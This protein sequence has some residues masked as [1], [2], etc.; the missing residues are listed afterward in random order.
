MPSKIKP[1]KL[2]DDWEN[3]AKLDRNVANRPVVKTPPNRIPFESLSN[4]TSKQSEV[5]EINQTG[6]SKSH[7]FSAT[8][9]GIIW[10]QENIQKSFQIFR[11]IVWSSW[12]ISMSYSYCKTKQHAIRSKQIGYDFLPL[13]IVKTNSNFCMSK[14]DKKRRGEGIEFVRHPN[15]Y[16]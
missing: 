5:S 2:F 4:I 16:Y 12:A 14:D 11:P 3:Q 7:L 1:K 15:Y 8:D 10:E 6:R 13:T 9:D